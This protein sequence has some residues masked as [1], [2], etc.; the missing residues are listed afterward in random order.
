MVYSALAHVALILFLVLYSKV[1]PGP[2][3]VTEILW[4]EPEEVQVAASVPTVKETPRDELQ[5]ATAEKQVHFERVLRR[6]EVEPHPQSDSFSDKMNERL[7]SLQE[8]AVQRASLS[9]MNVNLP[10][11][12]S[13]PAL[14]AAE[15]VTGPP[16]DLKHAEPTRGKPVALTRIEKTSRPV[17]VAT[18]AATPAPSKPSR[19]ENPQAVRNLAGMTLVGPVADRKVLDYAT[20]RYPE[21]A[22]KEAV[23]GSVRLHFVVLADGRIKET[24][25]VQ[26]TSG[27]EDF[28]RNAVAAL[29]AWQFEP[30]G[31]GESGEQWGEI[32]FNYRLNSGG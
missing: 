8:S 15:P 23:E 24:V 28:D 11:P 7:A 5:I 20:P 14:A 17:P 9:P 19:A 10:V 22:K 1:S 26:K 31:P 29:K 21:W 25:M 16:R 13:R 12:G 4:M 27:Y 32:T 30:L 3:V 6:A 18:V 2:E